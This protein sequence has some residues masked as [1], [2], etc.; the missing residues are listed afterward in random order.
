MTQ[1]DI[2]KIGTQIRSKLMALKLLDDVDR[3]ASSYQLPK[4]SEPEKRYLV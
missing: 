2:R 4:I 3:S 1:V